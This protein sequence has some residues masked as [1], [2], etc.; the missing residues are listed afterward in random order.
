L[1][2]GLIALVRDHL[3][4]EEEILHAAGFSEAADHEEIHREFEKRVVAQADRFE[5]G[6]DSE[7]DLLRFLIHD[8]VA[9]HMLQDDRK[10]FP[11]FAPNLV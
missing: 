7:A 5:R 9:K 8:I 1:V 10:F 11:L 3:R 6:E 2:R 4:N